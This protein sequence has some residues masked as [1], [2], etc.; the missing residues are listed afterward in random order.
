MRIVLPFLLTALALANGC[1]SVHHLKYDEEIPQTSNLAEACNY[2]WPWTIR[3]RGRDR[4]LLETTDWED[5][6]YLGRSIND[7]SIK[8]EIE[9]RCA[10]IDFTAG[11]EASVTVY[12][13][14]NVD[15][16]TRAG[17]SVPLIFASAATLSVLPMYSSDGVSLCL[18]VS[19]PDGRHLYG[20]SEGSIV[21][22][23]NGPGHGQDMKKGNPGEATL[24]LGVS[25]REILG[26]LL[27]RALHK[28]WIPGQ[29]DLAQPNCET[30]LNAIVE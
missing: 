3:V 6:T 29:G 7:G 30:A 15:R 28:A 24:R 11:G 10:G 8:R 26:G 14:T 19:L 2:E 27:L 1:V 21:E 18:E 22:I 25:Q 17:V 13:L 20:L 23:E 9:A 5:D 12:Y 16:M 4:S